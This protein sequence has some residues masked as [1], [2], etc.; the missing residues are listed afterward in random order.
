MAERKSF[1]DH[2][3]N[4]I[5]LL[6]MATGFIAII[7]A[8]GGNLRLSAFMV[9]LAVLLDFLDGLSARLLR[10]GS[11]LGR[12]LDSLSD[13][14]SFG[15]A[16][17][18][19]MYYI[20]TGMPAM[21]GGGSAVQAAPFPEQFITYSPVLL[22]LAGGYRLARFNISPGTS[23]FKGLP[24]PATGI[25]IAGLILTI[26]DSS[27]RQE[28]VDFIR[29]DVFC[30]LSILVLSLLMISKVPL[31][32][33]KTQHYR[34]S[35]NLFR[36]ILLAISATLIIFLHEMAVPLIIIIYLLFSLISLLIPSQEI[37]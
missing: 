2:I 28:A 27:P 18:V 7:I 25:F 13:L 17:A 34:L 29:T 22:V 5:T 8:I 24:I 14:V 19:L 21:T 9:L 15:A 35:G 37:R 6:N 16:P 36:Y 10:A 30:L 31:L 23:G 20:L 11:S 4:I 32:S 1:P 33:L 26:T 12:E 3:P